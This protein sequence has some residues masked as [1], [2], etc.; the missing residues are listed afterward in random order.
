MA[1]P[2]V[3]GVAALVFGVKGQLTPSQMLTLLSL[4]VKRYPTLDGKVISGGI[5]SAKAALLMQ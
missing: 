3:S 1:A 2:H 4:S 5:V